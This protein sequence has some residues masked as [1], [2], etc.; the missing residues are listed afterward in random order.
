MRFIETGK[1]VGELL[2]LLKSGECFI[3]VFD[4]FNAHPIK[5]EPLVAMIRHFDKDEVYVISFSHPDC[6]PTKVETLEL[7]AN[8]ECKKYVL[9]RKNLLHYVTM[10]NCVDI[11]WCIY[12]ETLN[13]IEVEKFRCKDTRSVPIMQMIKSFKDT[14]KLFYSSVQSMDLQMSQYETEFSEVL[15]ELE[16]SGLYVNN[17]ELGDA[18]LVD[19][20]QF[21][22]TQYNLH[23]PTSRPSNRFGNVNYAALNKKTGDR[24]CF[25][26]RYGKDGAIVMMDYESY[27]LRLFGNHV[28]FDLPNESLHGYLGKLY[29]GKDELTEEE[30]DLSKKITF[31]LIYGGITDDVRDNVPFMAK[32]ADFVDETWNNYKQNGY[33]ETWFYNRKLKSSIFD[34]KTNSYKVFNYLLQSAETERNCQVLRNIFEYLSDKTTQC[35]LYTYDAF[36]FDIPKNEFPLVSELKK[37]MNPTGDYPIRTYVGA[38]YGDLREVS[39]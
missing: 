25:V 2:G 33:V 29:H 11:G 27:H 24:D 9:N 35:V 26:S 5:N 7:I 6:I 31:N 1:D 23:T 30:Y 37:T 28:N 16:K 39:V 19:E 15:C 32:I 38:T 22:Y 3:H 18:S 10:K 12:S 21:V 17:F 36:L 14:F 34:D 13:T 4:R 20:N 8:T